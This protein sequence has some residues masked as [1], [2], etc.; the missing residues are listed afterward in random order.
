M[1]NLRTEHL[2][3]DPRGSGPQWA[4]VKDRDD[5]GEV[6]QRG[7]NIGDVSCVAIHFPATGE[8]RFYASGAIDPCDEHGNT[9]P[10]KNLPNPYKQ[11]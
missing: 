6:I 4:K 1:T 9:T 10:L 5:V 7:R 11:D 3:R 8:V 2:G